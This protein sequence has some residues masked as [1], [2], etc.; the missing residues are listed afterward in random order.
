MNIRTTLKW[1][2]LSTTVCLTVLSLLCSLFKF[3]KHYSS[4]IIDGRILA[5]TDFI[6]SKV[7]KNCVGTVETTYRWNFFDKPGIGFFHPVWRS[8]SNHSTF[9]TL[10]LL[11]SFRPQVFIS[12]FLI[13]NTIRKYIVIIIRE[14]E[15]W[16]RRKPGI[17]KHGEVWR[18]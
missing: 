17:G 5:P 14:F 12:A 7:S 10:A 13:C 8:M 18:Y 2:F 6:C 9:R 11:K 4:I 15:F 16:G 3:Y 1:I